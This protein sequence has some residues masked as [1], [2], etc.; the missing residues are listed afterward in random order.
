MGLHSLPA[1]FYSARLVLE[2]ICTCVAPR[3]SIELIFEPAPIVHEVS[4]SAWSHASTR[5][6][7]EMIQLRKR[8]SI[9]CN[10]QL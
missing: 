2:K 5:S 4:F 10:M 1:D 3:F 7:H 9:E 6:T 8:S